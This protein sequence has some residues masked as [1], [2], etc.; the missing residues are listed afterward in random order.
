MTDEKPLGW[1]DEDEERAVRA[2][3]AARREDPPPAS[4]RG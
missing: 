3:D 4:P 2:L 1:R